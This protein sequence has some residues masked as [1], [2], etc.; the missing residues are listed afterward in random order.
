VIKGDTSGKYVAREVVS[1]ATPVAD[2]VYTL[3][4]DITDDTGAADTATASDEVFAARTFVVS[5][6]VENP[7]HMY[8][9]TETEGGRQKLFGAM[10]SASMSFPAGQSSILNMSGLQITKWEDAA[11]ANPTYSE[12]TR[13]NQI[14][15]GDCPFWV[16]G[17]MFQAFDFDLDLGNTVAQ[18]RNE[19]GENGVSGYVVT[20][21]MPVL[22]GKIRA[23]ALTG[24]SEMSEAAM[25]AFRGTDK[26]SV[27]TADCGLQMGRDAGA[28]VYLRMPAAR[29]DFTRADENGQRV[30][31]FTATA[32][33]SPNHASVPGALRIHIF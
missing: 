15:V 24:P 20:N 18:R 6:S 29:L 9:D 1:Q 27:T 21:R 33:E 10:S 23:G 3:D 5:N 32:T 22:T 30:Y 2:L 4:R 25:E 16:D 28:A 8:F 31:S 7:I 12:P 26:F 19:G 14:I 11:K 13:G 17:T